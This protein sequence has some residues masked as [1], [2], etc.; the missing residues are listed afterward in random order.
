MKRMAKVM[1]RQRVPGRGVLESRSFLGPGALL[2]V[3]VQGCITVGPDYERPEVPAPDA[4][5]TAVA[6]EMAQ[7][8]PDLERW[9]ETFGDP[10]LTDLIRR[11][12]EANLDLRLA[13]GRVQEARALRG[14]ARGDY[15]PNL[16]LSGAYS[17]TQLSENSPAGQLKKETGEAVEPTDLWSAS[18][19]SFWEIDVFGRVRRSVEAADASLQASIEDYRDVLVSLYAEVAAN[20]VDLRSLQVR[21][22]FARSNVRGQEETVQLTRGRFRAGL[23][24]ALDVA[25]AE[26]NLANTQAQ[27]PLI[28]TALNASLNRLAVLLGEAPGSLNAELGMP[29]GIPS[30][31]P[32]IA[33]GLP[34]D[35]LRRRPDVRRAERQLASQTALIGVA[36][37]DL[38]PSFSL[39][40]FLELVA[41]GFGDLAQSES[42]GW[43]LVPGV[44]WNL[45]QGGK[46]R[47][48]IR[49]QE[50]RTEQALALYEK[51]VLLALEEVEDA[52][53]AYER[54]GVRRDLLVEAVDATQRSL[55]LV[56]TQYLSGLT[57]FQ[58]YLDAERSLFQ[59]QN[60][61][62]ASEGQVVKNLIGLN[63]A[64]GGGWAVTGEYFEPSLADNTEA[65]R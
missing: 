31:P 17:R 59:Q 4:W 50:A 7:E 32:D 3:F 53:V 1:K 19:D 60:Q 65:V 54:E 18:A 30:P 39:S 37:A 28:E 47:N 21:L 25:Q 64:L 23:V 13:V 27:V 8:T 51:A 58:R 42:V 41:P 33:A 44:R 57:D 26:S 61:L 62:A 34:V 49:V 12:E 15:Y 56:R 2:V 20:Y 10:T 40:G 35:L 63:R 6:Q 36:K 46:I 55:E 29:L 24:S 16:V 5:H 48:N 9:W 22:D 14:I 38:Y 45:F 52:L 11:A 43:G